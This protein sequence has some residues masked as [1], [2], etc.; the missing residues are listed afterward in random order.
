LVCPFC[1]VGQRIHENQDKCVE[2]LR[3]EISGLQRIHKGLQQFPGAAEDSSA[4]DRLM[5]FGNS[6]DPAVRERARTVLE[7]FGMAEQ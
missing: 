4:Y 1:G 7:Q 2:A 3:D 5:Q 6:V